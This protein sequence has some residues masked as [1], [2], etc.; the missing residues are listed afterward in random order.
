MKEHPVRNQHAAR[1]AGGPARR[2]WARQTR[3]K[4]AVIYQPPIPEHH[5]SVGDGNAANIKM[6]GALHSPACRGPHSDA[7]RTHGTPKESPLPTLS[8]APSLVTPMR[9]LPEQRRPKP[10]ADAKTQQGQKKKE[11]AHTCVHCFSMLLP[12][13][14]LPPC[15][16][17]AHGALCVEAARGQKPRSTG[18]KKK[19][20]TKPEQKEKKESEA[21]KE[22]KKKKS[23][24]TRGLNDAW[25]CGGKGHTHRSTAAGRK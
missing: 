13:P 11:R 4:A 1:E 16:A 22:K 10:G 20:E 25:Q 7:S 12:S 2:P 17:Q 3:K 5:S 6:L 9:R 19:E 18:G 8:I 24:Y 23:T 14:A 21:G 15:C